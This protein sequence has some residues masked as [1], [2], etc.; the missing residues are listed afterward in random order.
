MPQKI[1]VAIDAATPV[2][3]ALDYA[4]AFST[5]HDL[6]IGVFIEDLSYQ[7]YLTFFGEEFFAFDARLLRQTEQEQTSRLTEN[8]DLCRQ[9]CREHGVTF[10]MHV[11]KGVPSAE[12]IRESLFGDMIFI[13][14]RTFFSS[15]SGNAEILSDLLAHAECPVLAVPE[16]YQPVQ[17][18]LLAYDGKP[19]SVF[20]MRQFS[21][22][23]P[24][25]AARLPSV[26]LHADPEKN[27]H[28]K[29][30]HLQEY[31]SLHY[32]ALRVAQPWG[33]AEKELLA[34]AHSHPS[35]LVIMGAQGRTTLTSF[36]SRSMV[37]RLLQ[38]EAAPFFFSHR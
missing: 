36:F 6:I 10:R 2:G 26:L 7:S 5:T 22:L 31:L 12:L 20:A 1:L 14:Y 38:K 17:T 29:Q 30:V 18:L 3:G 27:E 34:A 32:P 16:T 24:E 8:I 23:F 37:Q 4:L 21:L 33:S 28:E 13:S 15:I 25:M 19:N 9:R 35:P 11:D